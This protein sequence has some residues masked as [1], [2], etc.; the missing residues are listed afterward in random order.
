MQSRLILS[1]AIASALCAPVP[2]SGQNQLVRTDD[3]RRT[4]VNKDVNGE[5]WAIT[6]DRDR[7]AVTGN[8]LLPAGGAT[9]IDCAIVQVAG[10]TLTLACRIADG[11]GWRDVGPVTLP[12]SFLEIPGDGCP[13]PRGTYTMSYVD[14]CGVRGTAEIDFINMPKCS[15]DAVTASATDV[16]IE[17]VRVSADVDPTGGMAFRFQYQGACQGTATGTGRVVEPSGGGPNGFLEGTVQG[18]TTC[19]GDLRATFGLRE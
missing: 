12:T 19:C 3:G 10:D 5:R 17:G 2:A 16:A 7:R 6:Y 14:S 18:S 4:L 9:F 15:L 13:E 11:A 8:V 1:L